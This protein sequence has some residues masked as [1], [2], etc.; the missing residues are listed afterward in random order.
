MRHFGLLSRTRP[1]YRNNC[2][3]IIHNLS[4]LAK[5]HDPETNYDKYWTWNM[6]TFKYRSFFWGKKKKNFWT[7]GIAELSYVSSKKG[8]HMKPSKQKL[9]EIL[10]CWEAFHLGRISHLHALLLRLPKLPQE[11]SKLMSGR[12]MI[13]NHWKPK[14]ENSKW[15]RR[16]KMMISASTILSNYSHRPLYSASLMANFARHPWRGFNCLPCWFRLLRKLPG[17]TKKTN[18]NKLEKTCRSA[19]RTWRNAKSVAKKKGP[20]D[21]II[22]C[23]GKPPSM[24]AGLSDSKTS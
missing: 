10:F 4:F 2:K 17:E 6:C 20:R 15:W 19:S 16:R 9:L 12:Q 1:W 8:K 18:K 11:L 21:I 23:C 22:C 14:I 7:S 3:Y 24:V 13:I 5:K